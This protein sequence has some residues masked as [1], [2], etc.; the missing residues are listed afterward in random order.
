[1][2]IYRESGSIY[3]SVISI[4]INMQQ[5]RLITLINLTYCVSWK[6]PSDF[7]LQLHLPPTIQY[8]HCSAIVCVCVCVSVCESIIFS[9]SQLKHV[10]V[11]Q[12][13][14]LTLQD[15]FFLSDYV[16]TLGSWGPA[17]AIVM[18]QWGLE[19]RKVCSMGEEGAST[20]RPDGKCWEPRGPVGLDR[21]QAWTEGCTCGGEMQRPYFALCDVAQCLV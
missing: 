10:S 5:G 19:I 8:S 20:W 11:E 1:M 4:M 16:R 6:L 15:G 21:G 9:V 12:H 13:H 2:W 14:P 7:S 18:V 3:S 17:S